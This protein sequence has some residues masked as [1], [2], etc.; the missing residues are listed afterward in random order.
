[1][2]VGAVGVLAVLFTVVAAAAANYRF[3]IFTRDRR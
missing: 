1:V 2:T 3:K